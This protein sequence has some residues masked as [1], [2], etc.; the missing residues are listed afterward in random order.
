MGLMGG[1][2]GQIDVLLK[3]HTA[4][5]FPRYYIDRGE[6]DYLA[7]DIDLFEAT[8]TSNGIPHEYHV[9]PGSH[10][11]AYWQAHVREYMDWYMAGWQ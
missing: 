7:G 8:L 1:D 4:A 9:S 2:W 6:D 11:P 5:E 10:A 3:T